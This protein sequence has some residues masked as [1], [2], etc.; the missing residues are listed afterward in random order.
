MV[1][2]VAADASGNVVPTR[3]TLPLMH[4]PSQ[5][6][7]VVEL[8]CWNCAETAT[9]GRM[10]ITANNAITLIILIRDIVSN[11]KTLKYSHFF[12]RSCYLVN[13]IDSIAGKVGEGVMVFLLHFEILLDGIIVHTKLQQI[14]QHGELAR[15]QGTV[16]QRTGIGLLKR[17][18]AF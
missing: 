6:L 9:N 12:N 4:S 10:A 14:V 2:C 13:C 15:L 8:R 5:T 18:L 3:L 1:I 17:S 16:K 7:A 11:F